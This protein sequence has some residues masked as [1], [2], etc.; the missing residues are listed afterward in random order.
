M[1]S[2]MNAQNSLFDFSNDE[3]VK[4]WLIVN[5]GVMG[6]LSKGRFEVIDQR[7]IFS[8]EVSTDNNGGFTMVRNQFE[9][10]PLLTYK[11]FV[12]E[13]KG[14]GKNYQFRVKSNANQRHSYV[15]TFTTNGDWQK[16]VIPFSSL[17]PR[18]RGR[19]VDISNFEGL[20]IE[21]IAFLIGNKKE[22]SF[23]LILKQVSLE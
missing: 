15:F 13:L 5:D 17:E 7:A 2:L 6:G 3:D 22:E 1:T 4:G 12:L 11:R 8:G 18:F 23:E 19:I 21:E 20:Q 10:Q 9:Q 16:I 14:D